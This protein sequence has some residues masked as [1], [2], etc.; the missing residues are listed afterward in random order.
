MPE[1]TKERAEIIDLKRKLRDVKD[2]RDR[3]RRLYLELLEGRSHN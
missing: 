2:E 3:Y 1:M